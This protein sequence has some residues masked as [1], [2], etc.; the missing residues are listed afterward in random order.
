LIREPLGFALDFYAFHLAVYF[1]AKSS[2][3]TVEEASYRGSKTANFAIKVDVN[4][5]GF[6]I[7]G[8]MIYDFW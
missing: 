4:G 8:Q 3:S 6:C 7:T 5:Y 2:I 1:R